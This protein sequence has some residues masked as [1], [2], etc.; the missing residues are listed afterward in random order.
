MNVEDKMNTR[1]DML[2]RDDSP[3]HVHMINYFTKYRK[4]IFQY[5]IIKSDAKPSSIEELTILHLHSYLGMR[6]YIKGI[7]SM[8]AEERMA[9]SEKG[10]ENGLGSMSAEERMAA[11]EKGYENGLGARSA[12][13]RTAARKKG[14]SNDKSGIS[15]EKKYTEFESY[16]GMPERGTPL[17]TWQSQQLN[18]T[19]ASCLNAKIRKEMEEN[20]GSTIWRERRVKLS[21]CLEQKNRAKMGIVWERKFVEFESYDEMPEKGTPLYNWQMNQLG[22]AYGICLNAK[23]RKEEAENKG[24]TVWS[25]RRV[26]LA[27][28]VAQKR[29][30]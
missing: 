6:G 14:S 16:D 24:S 4:E 9:A 7:G 27:K 8:S 25:E 22:N 26:K 11:S 18:N 28:C 3:G 29:R 19:H 13:A 5:A 17:Y 30:E 15:W 1:L 21:D 12:E 23:I 2:A 20:E 10:Y